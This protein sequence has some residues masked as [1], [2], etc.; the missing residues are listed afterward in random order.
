MHAGLHSTL[1]R[2]MAWRD[3]IASS[4]SA[5]GGRSEQVQQ[6]QRQLAEAGFTEE[7]TLV[8]RALL[9]DFAR[10]GV[11]LHKEQQE[12]LMAVTLDLHQASASFGTAILEY[13][14]VNR[15]YA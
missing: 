14:H 15:D 13:D 9:Q 6:Q 7:A 10:F 11:H 8:G 2:A 4:A 12:R 3:Q 5:S 1:V